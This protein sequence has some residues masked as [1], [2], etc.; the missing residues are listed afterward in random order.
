MTTYLAE[1]YF[2]LALVKYYKSLYIYDIK[3]LNG[4]FLLLSF[5]G[6]FFIDKYPDWAY[7]VLQAR[8]IIHQERTK[9]PEM[10]KE[11]GK[12]YIVDEGILP[13]AILKTAE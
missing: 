3:N 13:E 10:N 1:D 2:L 4:L 8:K 6:V 11:K 12:F 7:N 9:M 5:Y